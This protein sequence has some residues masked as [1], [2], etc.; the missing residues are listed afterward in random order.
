MGPIQDNKAA[1]VGIDKAKQPFSEKRGKQLGL[2]N[3]GL[4]RKKFWASNFSDAFFRA[5]K[6]T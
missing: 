5:T 2:P 1:W 4:I 3:I 6:S